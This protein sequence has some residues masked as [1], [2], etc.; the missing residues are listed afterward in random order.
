MGEFVSMTDKTMPKDTIVGQFIIPEK[1]TALEQDHVNL[2]N[3]QAKLRAGYFINPH[4]QCIKS[5]DRIIE[6]L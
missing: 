6:Q 2:R 3:N 5:T 1:A 4:K